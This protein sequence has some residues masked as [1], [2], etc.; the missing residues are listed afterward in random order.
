MQQ[1]CSVYRLGN[2]LVIVL[3]F[4][5]VAHR[6]GQQATGL[7][8]CSMLDQTLYICTADTGTDCIVAFSTAGLGIA[9][10]DIWGGHTLFDYCDVFGN[11]DGNWSGVALFRMITCTS[12]DPLLPMGR[13]ATST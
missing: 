13:T 8:T 10:N 2:M 7:S 3:A 4:H 1:A 5:G 12:K 11:A 6:N 9:G